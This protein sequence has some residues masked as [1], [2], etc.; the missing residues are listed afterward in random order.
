MIRNWIRQAGMRRTRFERTE[1]YGKAGFK[2]FLYNS[3]LPR[4]QNPVARRCV[5][6]YHKGGNAKLADLLNLKAVRPEW[7]SE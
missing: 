7:F 4:C 1:L 3:P 6:L 5:A 2:G